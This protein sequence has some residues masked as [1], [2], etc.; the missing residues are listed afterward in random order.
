[1]TFQVIMPTRTI[2]V[3]TRNMDID[4]L[5]VKVTSTTQKTPIPLDE[6][7]EVYIINDPNN[8]MMVSRSV[9]TS[10]TIVQVVTMRDELTRGTY[11]LH[12][13]SYKT[14]IG[15][16]WGTGLWSTLATS[17]LT[18]HELAYSTQMQVGQL[19]YNRK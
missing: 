5:N 9:V 14:G 12:T 16:A 3:N 10:T 13:N 4:R 17:Q 7:A 2:F 15:G 6:N 11:T 18:N 8:G 1:M 19:P